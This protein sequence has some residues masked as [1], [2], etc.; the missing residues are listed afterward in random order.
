MNLLKA[1]LDALEDG[2]ISAEEAVRAALLGR[3]TL[4]R[5]LK[6]SARRRCRRPTVRAIK[7]ISA[8]VAAAA[9]HRVAESYAVASVDRTFC[10][11]PYVRHA[12]V[13]RAAGPSG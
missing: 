3:T 13:S 10:V 12:A 8:F 1:A 5:V 2:H 4:A 9:V 7:Q 11:C 6:R